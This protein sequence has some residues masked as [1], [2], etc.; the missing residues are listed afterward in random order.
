MRQMDKQPGSRTGAKLRNLGFDIVPRKEWPGDTIRHAPTSISAL[1]VCCVSAQ[2]GQ[3]Q[4]S[5]LEWPLA[6]VRPG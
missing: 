2:L 6:I 5:L 3:A 4:A 1:L